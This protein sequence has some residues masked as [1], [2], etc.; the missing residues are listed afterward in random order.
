MNGRQCSGRTYAAPNPMNS[1]N[2]S[3]FTMTIAAFAPELAK[4]VQRRLGADQLASE[5]ETGQRDKR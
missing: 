3:T 5:M 4:N 1:S 2:T